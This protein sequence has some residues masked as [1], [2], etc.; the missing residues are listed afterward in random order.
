MQDSQGGA[1]SYCTCMRPFEVGYCKRDKH[2]CTKEDLVTCQIRC[3]WKLSVGP[4]ATTYSDP[5]AHD[6]ICDNLLGD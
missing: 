1:L 4:D 2:S 3:T 6:E 5:G